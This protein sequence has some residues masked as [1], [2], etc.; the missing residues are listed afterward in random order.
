MTYLPDSAVKW[1]VVHYSATYEDTDIGA[2]EID[3]MHR[4]RG[5][6]EIGYHKVI[7]LDGRVENGRDLSRP[8]AFEVGAQVKN[9]NSSS[10]GICYIGG[11]KRGYG[12]DRGF[13]TRTPAQTK[14]L[15]AEI[16]GMLKRFPGAK[17]VGHRDMPGAATQ[18]PGFDVAAW[19]AG[20]NA[21]TAS[22]RPVA[23]PSWLSRWFG[24]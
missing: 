4:M 9:H 3:Q 12:P 7:R 18:C 24:V 13:D 16:R 8:G 1:I 5:F 21:I 11:L 20:V 15:I 14:A 19:W 17:V 2:A 6:R 22:P 10:V 23:R